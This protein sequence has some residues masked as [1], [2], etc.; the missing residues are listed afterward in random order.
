MNRRPDASTVSYGALDVPAGPPLRTAHVDP[1]RQCAGKRGRHRPGRPRP[2]LLAR[3]GRSRHLGSRLGRLHPDPIGLPQQAHPLAQRATVRSFD[4][5]MA[6]SGGPTNVTRNWTG[7]RHREGLAQVD[8]VVGRRLDLSGEVPVLK[9]DFAAVVTVD[10]LVVESGHLAFQ[11]ITSFVQ[12]ATDFAISRWRDEVVVT[13]R[14]DPMACPCGS[15]ARRRSHRPRRARAR[16]VDA[17]PA[18]PRSRDRTR[19]PRAPLTDS[20]RRRS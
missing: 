6:S 1:P 8:I 4:N 20:P 13:A 19:A 17:S 3:R 9:D 2:P 14:L 10:G 15:R 12:S 18:R 7:A 5:L 11:D 16:R